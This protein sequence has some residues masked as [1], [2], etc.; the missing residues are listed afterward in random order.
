MRYL[1]TRTKETQGY[2]TQGRKDLRTYGLDPSVSQ[3]LLGSTPTCGN[4]LIN[5]IGTIKQ[6]SLSNTTGR[7]QWRRINDTNL[8]GTRWTEKSETRTTATG[9][10]TSLKFFLFS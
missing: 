8:S 1:G 4:S 6:C 2:H 10:P 5:S 7:K 9:Q 3:P